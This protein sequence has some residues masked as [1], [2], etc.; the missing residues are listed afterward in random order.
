[1]MNKL[2]Y[3]KT[4][5]FWVFILLDSLNVKQVTTRYSHEEKKL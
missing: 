4:H 2:N 5:N 1:M 3:A